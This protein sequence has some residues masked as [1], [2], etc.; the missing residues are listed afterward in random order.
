M[1][2]LNGNYLKILQYLRRTGC[3]TRRDLAKQM[4]LGLSMVS[5]LTGELLDAGV[6]RE[7]GRQESVGGRPSDILS[8]APQAGYAVGLDIGGSHQRAILVDLV[9]DVVARE[10]Y[11]HHLPASREGI[12]D[13]IDALVVQLQSSAG[14]PIERIFGLGVGLWGSVDPRGGVVYS[15]TET[16]ELYATWKD[17]ALQDALLARLPFP[18]VCIDD[19]VR[20]MGLAEVLYGASAARDQDFLFALADTGIGV[21]IMIGGEPYVGPNQLAGEIG[22]IPIGG[23]QRCNCGSIGCIET[24]ASVRAILEQAQRKIQETPTATNLSEF[25]GNLTIENVIRAAE[26]SDKVA[27]QVITEAGE[28]FGI[29]L[30]MAVNMFGPRLVIVGG[31]LANSHVYLDAAKRLVRFQALGK[32]N[33][34]LT[35]QPSQLDH[36]AGA[37]GAASQVLN[38]L[39]CPGK[40]NLLGLNLRLT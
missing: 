24:M 22:H 2:M 4:G 12:V 14:V 30:A 15:W 13:Q 21:A 16:P 32:V 27:Y 19:V 11:E 8:L 20:T 31:T 3:L 38:R 5:R 35:I 37:R 10:E 23:S 39:F 33:S 9:G 1:N 40:K 6:I 17:F 18:H 36:L 26:L 34:D 29:G 28:K 7:N 25:A